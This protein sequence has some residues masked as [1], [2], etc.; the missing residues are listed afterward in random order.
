MSEKI[1][2]EC[3]ALAFYDV[4][5]TAASVGAFLET[6]QDWFGRCGFA[7]THMGVCGRGFSRK[8][9]S[10]KA[11]ASRLE[12][13]GLETVTDVEVVSAL[14][15]AVVI[16]RDYALSAL[17]SS[18]LGH[19]SIV[20]RSGIADLGSATFRDLAQQLVA[21]AAPAY[22]IGYRRP[23]ALGPDLYAA[24]V[25]HGLDRGEA[26]YVEALNAS[27]WTDARR[28]RVWEAGLLRD[29]YEWNFLSEDQLSA[30]VD[31]RELRAWIDADT[32]RGRLGPAVGAL[33]LWEVQ[34]AALDPIRRRL[35]DAGVIFN[36]ARDVEGAQ[37]HPFAA[38]AALRYGN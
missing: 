38:R 18:R 33:T 19:L 1:T 7:P 5:V 22:G 32:G 23:H 37:D 29:V 20:A 28:Q 4:G 17:L 35:W 9:V 2:D 6:V 34:P 27:F 21:I 15:G 24:G 13:L 3:S 14:P 8:L 30:Q 26:D 31:G 36:W 11:A 12:R 10:V 16:G 25:C